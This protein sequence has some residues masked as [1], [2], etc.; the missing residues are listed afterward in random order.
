MK[1]TEPFR[2]GPSQMG[3]AL[4]F[5]EKEVTGTRTGTFC[6]RKGLRE[7]GLGGETGVLLTSA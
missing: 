1:M 2:T 4:A 3:K 7:K 5:S 6:C